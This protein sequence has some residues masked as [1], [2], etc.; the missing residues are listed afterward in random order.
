MERT[1]ADI[2]DYI[3]HT[4][5]PKDVYE[6]YCLRSGALCVF[7]DN[8]HLDLFDAIC[9]IFDYGMARGYRAAKCKRSHS[10]VVHESTS[11]YG[12]LSEKVT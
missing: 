1:T 5:I 12:C 3:G 2:L 7:Y 6:K 4:K 8:L 9:L 10:P 11:D